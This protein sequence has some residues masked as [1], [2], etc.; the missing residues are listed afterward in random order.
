M[1]LTA[2]VDSKIQEVD[3]RRATKAKAW[4]KSI[5]RRLQSRPISSNRVRWYGF[6]SGVELPGE[7]A[8][9]LDVV[10]FGT[11]VQRVDA[12]S[13]GGDTVIAVRPQGSFDYLAFQTDTVFTLAVSRLTTQ[14]QKLL[15]E[16]QKYTGE[17]LSLN[18]KTLRCAKY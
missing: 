1:P 13:E 5:C 4:F 18:F 10:D 8:R 3:F 17:T 6:V 2:A 9:R 16:T 14:E 7:L 11:P 12:F 15:E